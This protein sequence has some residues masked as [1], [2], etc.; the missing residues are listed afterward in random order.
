MTVFADTSAIYAVLDRDDSMHSRASAAWRELLEGDETLL[1]SNYVILE[2]FALVQSRLGMVALRVLADD[3]LAVIAAEWIGEE[4]HRAAAHA[5]LAADRRSLSLVDCTSFA[6][7]RRLGVDTS[8]TVDR[9]F[10]EQ[11]FRTLPA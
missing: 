4:E 10:E 8:F 6:L 9:H 3:V 5:V 7:M 1:T 2:S 11:G